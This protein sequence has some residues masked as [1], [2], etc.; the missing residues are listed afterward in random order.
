MRAVLSFILAAL[1]LSGC[2]N[3]MGRPMLKDEQFMLI[4]NGMTREDTLRL[5]GEPDQTMKFPLSRTEAWDYR[6]Q[7][8][9][10]YLANYSVTFGADGRVVSKISVRPNSGGD[11]G[12]H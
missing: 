12:R 2:A 4:Q 7:D 10:G 6:Y 1:M 3:S 11:H 5:I 9:W 8:T